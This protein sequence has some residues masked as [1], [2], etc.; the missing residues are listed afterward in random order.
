MAPDRL[1]SRITRALSVAALLVIAATPAHAIR[2][3]N[4][5]LLNYPGTSAAARDTNY[6]KIILNIRPDLIVT[7]EMT[8][9]TVLQAVA[10]LDAHAAGL[11]PECRQPAAVRP[12]V[13]GAPLGLH[14]GSE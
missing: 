4:W 2:V 12:R 13:R 1:R 9:Q 5:N 11:L 3:L 10:V 8:S 14:D 7:E 6:R